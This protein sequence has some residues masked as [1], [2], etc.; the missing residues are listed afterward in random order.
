MRIYGYTG[1]PTLEA[2]RSMPFS[3]NSTHGKAWTGQPKRTQ[4]QSP[5]KEILNK[6]NASVGRKI[7]RAQ[8]QIL[9]ESFSG[10][11][12][13]WSTT[14][15]QQFAYQLALLFPR[16]AEDNGLNTAADSRVNL[17]NATSRTRNPSA[18]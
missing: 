12:V 9:N 6:R 11:H 16:A 4:Q 13:A 2:I 18:S 1:T 7:R 3:K 5:K 14:D 17:I 15:L 10:G 8:N